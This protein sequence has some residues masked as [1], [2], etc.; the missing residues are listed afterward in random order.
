MISLSETA[1]PYIGSRVKPLSF[2]GLEL[3][4]LKVWFLLQL[5]FYLAMPRLK[6]FKKKL[7]YRQFKG[8]IEIPL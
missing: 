2:R 1:D 7:Y 4:E 6:D 3:S 8:G 5:G